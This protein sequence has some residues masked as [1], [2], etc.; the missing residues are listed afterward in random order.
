M[1]WIGTGVIVIDCK[2]IEMMIDE[3][4]VEKVTLK[5]TLR[6]SLKTMMANQSEDSLY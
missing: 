1:K 2:C 6:V 3:K 4:L 5:Q